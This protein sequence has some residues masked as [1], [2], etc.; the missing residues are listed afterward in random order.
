MI[1][2]H[3]PQLSERAS[4]QDYNPE[5]WFPDEPRGNNKSW[6]RTPDAMKARAI[7]GDCPALMECRN[8]ALAYSGLSGIWGGLDHVERQQLQE[9]LG[10][11]PIFMANT[12]DSTVFAIIKD[13]VSL[14]RE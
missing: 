9:K 10:I 2:N 4:C 5:W 3:F 14:D 12:Y 11:T 7:C 8:Y 6:S 1:D 13:G